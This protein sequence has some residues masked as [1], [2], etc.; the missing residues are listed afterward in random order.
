MDE[1]E[2]MD[3]WP[4]WQVLNNNSQSSESFNPLVIGENKASPADQEDFIIS[5]LPLFVWAKY[6]QELFNILPQGYFENSPNR[7]YPVK[8]QKYNAM[9]TPF[10]YAI[11]T[12]N[13][14]NTQRKL[15]RS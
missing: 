1:L 15:N 10:P 11:E 3:L 5:Y 4:D 7:N 12:A 6:S 13:K 2:M 9:Q 14:T 8:R